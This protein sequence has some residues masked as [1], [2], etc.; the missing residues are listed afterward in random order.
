MAGMGDWA[1]SGCSLRQAP[2]TAGAL[3][4][5][6]P[7]TDFR[8]EM[9]FAWRN[10][11]GVNAKIPQARRLLLLKLAETFKKWGLESLKPMGDNVCELR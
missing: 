7:S 2:E 5:I 11:A 1:G 6:W 4:A 8:R 3:H 9:R 10:L